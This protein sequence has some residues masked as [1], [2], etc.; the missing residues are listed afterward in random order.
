VQRERVSVCREREYVC[1]EREREYVC[2]E[3][4]RERERKRE[5][6]RLTECLE[7]EREIIL[8]SDFENNAS[9]AESCLPVGKL[10]SLSLKTQP[11]QC[12]Y[13][14]LWFKP[15]SNKKF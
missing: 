8:T 13:S 6:E 11:M 3:R 10:A 1:G 2:A 9:C 4:E 5:R 7:R 15:K 12:S 14:F